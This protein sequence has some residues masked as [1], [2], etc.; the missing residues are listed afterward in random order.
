MLAAFSRLRWGPTRETTTAW[1]RE[2]HKRSLK[3]FAVESSE[4]FLKFLNQM[5]RDL[6]WQVPLEC[7]SARRVG[8]HMDI[9]P[10]SD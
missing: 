5:S 4:E 6:A 3:S 2:A 9:T 8:A 10:L 1:I 7:F